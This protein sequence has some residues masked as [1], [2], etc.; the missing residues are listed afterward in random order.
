MDERKSKAAYNN[1]QM[2]EV[3]VLNIIEHIWS[4]HKLTRKLDMKRKKRT[5]DIHNKIIYRPHGV[6]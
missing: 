5:S 6:K 3:T 1:E 4:V 2:I